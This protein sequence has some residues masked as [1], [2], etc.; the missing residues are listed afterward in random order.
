MSIHKAFFALC[1]DR[2]MARAEEAGL[3]ESRRRLVA[4]AT[5]EVLEIGAGTG[6]NLELYGPGVAALTVTEPEPAMVRRLE[7]HV[8]ERA[9][10][11]T[12]LRAPAEDLPFEDASFDVVVSTLVLCGVADQ[13]R[14]LRQIGRVLRP[15][16]RLL[17]LE[18]VRSQE[19]KLA[20]TQDRLNWLNRLVVCC[21]CN[22]PTL[23][24]IKAAGFEVGQVEHGVLPKAPPFVRPLILGTARWPQAPLTDAPD[25]RTAA[26]TERG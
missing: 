15:G 13:P 20:R 23:D 3:R 22:R 16:G 2:Q 12:V 26:G 25:L 18:H 19:P 8:R 24:S 17:F 4:E 5:G 9:P 6:A 1:Y 21:E 10:H 7:R 14:A 11:A